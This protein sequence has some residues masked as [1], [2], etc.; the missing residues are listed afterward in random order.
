MHQ[1]TKNLNG[2]VTKPNGT[3]FHYVDGIIT[4]P[5]GPAYTSP[6]GIRA[7][8][9]GEKRHREDGPAWEDINDSN[10]N[11]YYLNDTYIEP[12]SFEYKMIQAREKERLRREAQE[13]TGA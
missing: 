5:D 12:G 4:N 9:I 10:N 13:E 11:I 8:F 6:D 3:R 2:W 1:Y 7:Y